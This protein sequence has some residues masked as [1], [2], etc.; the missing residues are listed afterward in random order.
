MSRPPETTTLPLGASSIAPR[1][2]ER[3]GLKEAIEMRD[4]PPR[5]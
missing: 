2:P 1:S 3:R 5:R 4:A